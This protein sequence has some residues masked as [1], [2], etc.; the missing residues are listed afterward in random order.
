MFHFSVTCS[1]YIHNIDHNSTHT[2]YLQILGHLLTVAKNVAHKEGLHE[3]YRLGKV[4]IH[5]FTL[6]HW[7]EALQIYY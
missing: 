7:F 1:Y 6:K 3:G 5:V 2:I 4:N